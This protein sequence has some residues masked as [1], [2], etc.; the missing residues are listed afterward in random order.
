MN[1]TIVGQGAMGLLWYHQLAKDSSNHL[2]LVCSSRIKSVPKTTIFSDINNE[3]TRKPLTLANNSALYNAELILIC[4]KSYQIE[5]VLMTLAE[6]INA[7]ATVI[8]CHNGMVDVNLFA[9]LKNACYALLTTH[10][11]KI[12][13]P[14]HVQ[15]T[16]LGHNDLGLISGKAKPEI[17]EKLLATLTRALPSLTFSN[18]IKEQQ[19]LK[20][21][22]NCVINPITA[23]DNVENGQLLN[24]KY[25]T[26]I[27]KLLSEIIIVAADENVKFD[28]NELQ[29]SVRQVAKYTAKNCSSMRSDILQKRKT[30]INDINGYIVHLAKKIGFSVPENEKLI[31][32]VKMLEI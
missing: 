12:V 13:K 17:Q 29:E 27:D 32:Q 11:S 14:F 2:S 19:W 3:I 9:P 20:L 30:E 24:D 5:S 25:T 23:I 21:A 31:Q 15:H 26:V 18:N 4:V 8:F 10:G 16:G 22:I 6:Q 1:I 7:S 28:F